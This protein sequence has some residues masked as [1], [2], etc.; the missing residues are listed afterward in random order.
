MRFSRMLT[1]VTVAVL[2]VLTAMEC[3]FVG[4]GLTMEEALEISRNAPVVR[5][6]LSK[7]KDSMVVKVDYLSAD[8][9][10]SEKAKWGPYDL[11]AKLPDN[12]GVWKV[13]YNFGAEHYIYHYVDELTGRIL[14]E[15]VPTFG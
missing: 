1:V 15:A 6:A 14:Y 2:A 7:A 13:I 12:H 11:Y 9:I 5:K 8:Y 10:R 3:F 4:G